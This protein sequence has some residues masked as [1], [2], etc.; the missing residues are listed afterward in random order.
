[1]GPISLVLSKLF[2]REKI[3]YPKDRAFYEY[4]KWGPTLRKPPIDR[5]MNAVPGTTV[6]QATEWHDEFKK[7]ESL[8]WQLA[9]K[10][11]S[12]YLKS[13]YVIS[14]IQEQFPFLVDKG[15]TQAK[16]LVDYYAWHEGYDKTYFEPNNPSI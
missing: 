10:G 13:E 8:I 12:K 16:S 7:V 4:S 1:M 2:A 3:R 11:G 15:L 6:S 5:I 14:R 9:E